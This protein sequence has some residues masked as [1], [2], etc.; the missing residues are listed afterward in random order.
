MT[1]QRGPMKRRRIVAGAI[2]ALAMAMLGWAALRMSHR[3]AH[4]EQG[5]AAPPDSSAS[6]FQAVMLFFPA[7]SG[8]SLV[9]ESRS[10]IA[11]TDLHAR[12]GTLVTELARGPSAGGGLA[13]VPPET[14][15]LHAYLDD[16]GLLTLDLAPPFRDA[17]RGGA[18]AELLVTGALVR[19]LAANVP[20]AHRLQLACGGQPLA[21]LAG[22][23]PLDQ[24]IDL[25]HWP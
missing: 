7:P 15:L 18:T 12:V 23:V 24:P 9:G 10:V 4:L 17:F 22:H 13:L 11:Q 1:A 19:T 3:V 2:V 6:G 20:E 16:R 8:E 21:S 5:R 25:S 14:T